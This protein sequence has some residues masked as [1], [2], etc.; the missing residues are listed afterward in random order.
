MI[1]IPG[2]EILSPRGCHHPRK[3]T[4][5]VRMLLYSNTQGRNEITQGVVNTL[6]ILVLWQY[7]QQQYSYTSYTRSSSTGSNT[8][9][10]QQYSQHHQYAAAVHTTMATGSV[11]VSD[12]CMTRTPLTTAWQTIKQTST[13]NTYYNLLSY[14]VYLLVSPMNT[15][16]PSSEVDNGQGLFFAILIVCDKNSNKHML[17]SQL[18]FSMEYTQ[19]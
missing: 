14:C 8:R 19:S 10:K 16:T 3:S 18:Y 12:K 7:S 13:I 6:E 15:V 9:S 1:Q 5:S 17:L 11:E 4:G 2:V